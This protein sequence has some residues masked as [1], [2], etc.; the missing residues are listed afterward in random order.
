MNYWPRWINAIRKR[1]ASL[2]LA[3]MGAYD[4]LLDHYYAEEA[5]LPGTVEECCRIAGAM[6]R[7][8]IA[9]VKFVL[10]KFFALTDAGYSNDRADDEIQ[11]A[12]PKIAAAR[13]NGSRGGRPTGSKKKPSG[14]PPGTQNEPTS[15]A[16]YPQSKEELSIESSLPP[17]EPTEVTPARRAEPPPA[18]RDEGEGRSV[19]TPT[20]AG[21]IC[22]ALRKAGIA[23]VA[24]GHP[25]LLALIDAGTTVDEL[26]AFVPRALEAQDPF[27]YLLGTVAGERKRAAQLQASVAAG[28]M[29]PLRQAFPAQPAADSAAAIDPPHGDMTW[30]ARRAGEADWAWRKRLRTAEV[31]RPDLIAHLHRPQTASQT[32]I[33][34]DV[35]AVPAR[36]GR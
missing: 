3:Q 12:L 13:A 2:S 19:V 14:F 32:V 20:A 21:E 28:V 33:E 26:L 6:T 34:G 18:V 23:N 15:K 25:K 11:L 24:P 1:T 8:E 31:A 10:G 9:A 7:D 17:P 35:H 22:L 29:P 30:A 4:R 5:P 27:A 36:L 16:P